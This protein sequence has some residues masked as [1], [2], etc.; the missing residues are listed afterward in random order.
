[1]NFASQFYSFIEDVEFI[2]FREEPGQ[3]GYDCNVSGEHFCGEK[4]HRIDNSKLEDYSFTNNVGKLK[5]ALGMLRD[6]N[7]IEFLNIEDTVKR[8]GNF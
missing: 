4:Y 8:F 3:N 5:C 6:V 2:R 7:G 1:M